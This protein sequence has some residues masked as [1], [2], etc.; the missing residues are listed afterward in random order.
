MA[1][2]ATPTVDAPQTPAISLKKGVG[3]YKEQA[4]GLQEY[5]AKLEEQGDEKAHV[6][7]PCNPVEDLSSSTCSTRITFRFGILKK[8]ILL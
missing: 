4:G 6:H 8:N 2:I 7:T 3:D 5:D 1:P